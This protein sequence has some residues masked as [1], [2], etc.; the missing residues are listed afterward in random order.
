MTAI[1]AVLLHDQDT[2]ADPVTFVE[3]GHHGSATRPTCGR[4]VRS[5]AYGHRRHDGSLDLRLLRLSCDQF[6]CPAC[7]TRWAQVQARRTLDGFRPPSSELAKPE[8]GHQCLTRVQL[9]LDCYKGDLSPEEL[10]ALASDVG[11]LLKSAGIVKAVWWLHADP[12]QVIRGIDVLVD[13]CP[14]E[15]H[16]EIITPN[17]VEQGRLRSAMFGVPLIARIRRLEV[18]RDRWLER[19]VELLLRSSRPIVRVDGRTKMGHVT[20]R[21]GGKRPHGVRRP[22]DAVSAR[23]A[24]VALPRSCPHCG[25]VVPAADW[26]Y[27]RPVDA[28]GRPIEVLWNDEE[29]H[30]VH[31]GEGDVHWERVEAWSV[32]PDE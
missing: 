7:S 3:P 23:P 29:I 4:L 9:Q 19:L 24:K 13:E 27:Y 31:D 22:V 15:L 32:R 16:I 20:H 18:H 5:A 14:P 1:P 25:E 8:S 17:P 21:V 28:S 2:R 30:S 6:G 10:S 11:H 26:G 12:L